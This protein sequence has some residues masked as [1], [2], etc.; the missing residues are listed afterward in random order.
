[1]KHLLHAALLLIITCACQSKPA[2]HIYTWSQYLDPEVIAAFEAREHCRVVVDTFSSNEELFAKIKNMKGSQA[3]DILT[4][5][6]YMTGIMIAD[7]LLEELPSGHKGLDAWDNLD[8]SFLDLD[9]DRGNRYSMPYLVGMTGMAWDE[10]RTKLN[11]DD[12]SWKIFLDPR[13][14]NQTGILNDMRESFAVAAKLAG[15]RANETDPQALE[16]AA[17]TIKLLKENSRTIIS[18]GFEQLLAS[19]EIAIA[20]AYNNSLLS[21][22]R[23]R[24]SLRFAIP[25]EGGVIWLDNMA[26]VKGAPKKELALRFLN[27]CLDPQIAA[28]N[29]LFAYSATP[30]KNA[31]RYLPEEFS[32]DPAL[33]PPREA[34][35]NKLEWLKNPGMTVNAA[36]A[37][38]WNDVLSD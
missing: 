7:G 17:Q 27:H 24:S 13:F 18:D 2:L 3:Y 32:K 36:Y 5:S 25:K 16:A 12:L 23:Q 6:D 20:H 8:S 1:M 26:I 9:F 29:S 19:G 28:K 35:G 11:A 4:P 33:Y 37:R 34:I 30:N 14:K 31:L 22:K 38:L 15:R 10:E 21:L